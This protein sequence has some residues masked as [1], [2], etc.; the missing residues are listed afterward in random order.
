MSIHRG[1]RS[2]DVAGCD[3]RIDRRMFGERSANAPRRQHQQAPDPLQVRAQGVENLGAAP[4]PEMGGQRLVKPDVVRVETHPVPR[5]H[6]LA[7]AREVILQRLQ[8]FARH[9]PRRLG[10]HFALQRA[11][12]EHPLA[13]VGGRNARDERAVLRL[14]HH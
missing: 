11:A 8:A 3:R 1:A 14:D 9:A 2:F 10:R 12:D 13:H 6:R 5:F 7:L 4:Q